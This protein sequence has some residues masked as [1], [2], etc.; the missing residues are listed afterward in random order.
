MLDIFFRGL[1]NRAMNKFV[2]PIALACSLP[3]VAGAVSFTQFFNN[4][5]PTFIDTQSSLY[6]WSS[7][8]ANNT[9][10]ATNDISAGNTK[11]NSLV[12][13]G[14]ESSGR[15]FFFLLPQN[16]SEG[17]GAIF[18]YTQHTGVSTVPQNNPQPDWFATDSSTTLSGLELGD[19]N[20]FRYQTRVGSASNFE[21]RVAVEVGGSWYV[22][23]S[24]F[25]LNDTSVWADNVLNNPASE[26]WIE[27]AFNGGVLDDDVLVGNATTSLNSTD[28]VTGYGIY[29]DLEAAVGGASRIRLNEFEI[30]AVPEP[31]AFALFTG[32]LALGFIARRRR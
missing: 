17:G 31:S 18:M 20:S 11:S 6:N 10:M 15:G 25:L 1:L 8:S 2:T 13:P 3:V 9:A 21:S 5:N 26:T 12:L 16:S 24:T 23:Q 30:N 22:S 19:I 27:D 32:V 7:A 29:V 4:N 28:V 14:E